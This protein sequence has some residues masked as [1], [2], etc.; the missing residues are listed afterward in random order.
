MATSGQIRD[1]YRHISEEESQISGNVF[2]NDGRL[3][4][5]APGPH[6]DFRVIPGTL[7]SQHSGDD[8][9]GVGKY[10]TL[11]INEDG[12]Y[13]YTITDVAG[14]NAFGEGVDYTEEFKYIE[15]WYEN[16]GT[17][18][19]TE[20]TIKITIH[21]ENDQPLITDVQVNA[22]EGGDHAGE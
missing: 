10:G 12:S 5:N 4:V 9:D 17:K 16:D 11:T 13:V 2:D 21:G 6:E 22:F 19:E 14:V 3:G 18:R 15:E 7:E 8:T 1:D 20:K